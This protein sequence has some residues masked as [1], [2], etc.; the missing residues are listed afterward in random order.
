MQ[1]KHAPDM[2]SLIDYLLASLPEPVLIHILEAN[3]QVFVG[4]DP[5]EMV[6]QINDQ[7]ITVSVFAIVWETLYLPVLHP[8]HHASLDWKQL[9]ADL[10]MQRLD[11]VIEEARQIRL[12][13]YRTCGRCGKTMH[14]EHMHRDK[15]CQSCAENHLGIVH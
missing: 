9:A 5:G 4:G 1:S 2:Q 3:G 10:L 14:P 15:M 11:D 13:R 8:E 6:V 12:R 7:L